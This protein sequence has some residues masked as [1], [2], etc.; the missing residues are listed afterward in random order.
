[1]VIPSCSKFL[2]RLLFISADAPTV[3]IRILSSDDP[4]G[5]QWTLGISLQASH[6]ASVEH[7]VVVRKGKNCPFIL[8]WRGRVVWGSF[9]NIFEAGSFPWLCSA[10]IPA[11]HKS[12]TDHL[13]RHTSTTLVWLSLFSVDPY[14]ILVSRNNRFVLPVS[15]FNRCQNAKYIG[16]LTA[17]WSLNNSS[18]S[19][20][21]LKPTN[22]FGQRIATES[23]ISR[24]ANATFSKPYLRKLV[25]LLPP[26][27]KVKMW[28]R[29]EW[30]AKRV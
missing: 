18:L 4:H 30:M 27:L 3:S 2:V 15:N 26:M 21:L 11:S 23:L 8:S 14:L 10:S 7:R 16:V 13:S 17:H 25:H 9:Q 5:C 22:Q 28:C 20:R 24:G 29:K 19:A 12:K 1:M 6:S